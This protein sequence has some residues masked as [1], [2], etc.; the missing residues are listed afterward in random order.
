MARKPFAAFQNESDCI[1]PSDLAI[2][3]R[4]DRAGLAHAGQLKELLDLTVAEMEKSDLPE[5]NAVLE[6]ETVKNPFA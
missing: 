2:E 5:Q 3:N 6:A 1:E 4:L